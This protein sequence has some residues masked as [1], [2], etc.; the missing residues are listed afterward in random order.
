MRDEKIVC[1]CNKI[2][3]QNIRKAVF[4]GANTYEE[5]QKHLK[6]GTC[7][8][9]CNDYAKNVSKELFSEKKNQNE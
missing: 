1:H 8:K 3:V 7:C 2:T 6:V 4:D 9:R 5:L